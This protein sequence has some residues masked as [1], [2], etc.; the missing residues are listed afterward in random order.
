YAYDSRVRQVDSLTQMTHDGTFNGQR[1]YDAIARALD[2][3]QAP[4]GLEPPRDTFVLVFSNGGLDSGS[5]TNLTSVLANLSEPALVHA[6]IYDGDTVVSPATT[7][8]G[9]ALGALD[10]GFLAVDGDGDGAPFQINRVLQAVASQTQVLYALAVDHGLPSNLAATLGLSVT[11]GGLTS[12]PL[13]VSI[14]AVNAATLDLTTDGLTPEQPAGG[15]VRWMTRVQAIPSGFLG[16]LTA[17]NF[18]AT[19]TNLAPPLVAEPALEPRDIA[20]VVDASYSTRE[21]NTLALVKEA[22]G[23]LEVLVRGINPIYYSFRDTGPADGTGTIDPVGSLDAIAAGTNPG[24]P[25]RFYDAVQQAINATPPPKTVVI[26]A[27]GQDT[28]SSTGAGALADLIATTETVVYSIAYR[29]VGGAAQTDHQALSQFSGRYRAVQTTAELLQAVLDTAQEINN[30]Y[31]LTHTGPVD[32]LAPASVQL[33][34]LFE[35][36]TSPSIPGP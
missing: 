25:T 36:A 33:R 24:D 11:Y 34:A 31:R 18:E 13:P 15:M 28:T 12:A 2:G 14:P 7:P 17:A 9:T 26:F 5:T 6:I 27:G 8:L 23:L 3:A 10:P 19:D 30:T 35:S 32:P 16:G 29:P 20:F 4:T 21:E 1:A 22:A